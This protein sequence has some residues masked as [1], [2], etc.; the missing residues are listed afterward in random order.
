IG[1]TSNNKIVR[2]AQEETV[3]KINLI[4]PAILKLGVNESDVKTSNFDISPVYDYSSSSYGNNTIQSYNVNYSL[5][6]T[7]NDTNIIGSIIDESIKNGANSSFNLQFLNKNNDNAYLEALKNAV[8]I[9][10]QK[11]E[12]LA[13]ASGLKITKILSIDENLSNNYYMYSKSFSRDEVMD[14]AIAT[15]ILSGELS[16]S[17]SINMVFEAK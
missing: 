13:S 12:I 11:A 3:N 6:V 15:P 16:V 10:K 2:T 5:E 17:A 4:I 14:S 1:V 9:A 8:E 7:I